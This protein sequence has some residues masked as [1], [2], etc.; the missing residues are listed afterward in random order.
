[1]AV[2]RVLRGYFTNRPVDMG[3]PEKLQ[4]RCGVPREVIEQL[5]RE[6]N[7][8][9]RLQ[10]LKGHILKEGR[11]PVQIVCDAFTAS[12]LLF[13]GIPF[14]TESEKTDEYVK[15]VL[16]LL[17]HLDRETERA[18]LRG[19]AY[20]AKKKLLLYTIG[21]IRRTAEIEEQM[22]HTMAF[23]QMS[24]EIDFGDERMHYGGIVDP[25]K[26]QVE[27]GPMPLNIEAEMVA[28]AVKVKL[29][30]ARFLSNVRRKPQEHTTMLPSSET[31]REKLRVAVE[32][33]RCLTSDPDEQ[34]AYA[35]T[36]TGIVFPVGKEPYNY[37]RFGSLLIDMIDPSGKHWGGEARDEFV[38]N[39]LSND[40]VGLG[41]FESVYEFKRPH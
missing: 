30:H 41:V 1:M 13:K 11:T 40:K 21:K 10:A 3:V 19:S 9:Q 33:I 31:M 14:R 38:A 25:P 6:G 29:R 4:R 17:A 20:T 7:R 22:R 12:W 16:D 35:F 39:A 15:F 36:L 27:G 28:A 37:G 26:E 2:S 18:T 24:P 34:L 8:E 23:H 5:S 32:N